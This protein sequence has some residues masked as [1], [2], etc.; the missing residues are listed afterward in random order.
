[1]NRAAKVIREIE[2]G[3][4]TEGDSYIPGMQMKFHKEQ[5]HRTRNEII[6]YLGSVND[7][8]EKGLSPE[9]IKNAELLAEWLDKTP[10]PQEI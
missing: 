2:A 9:E 3:G 4:E 7:N 5:L 1:M 6:D 8:A 10:D